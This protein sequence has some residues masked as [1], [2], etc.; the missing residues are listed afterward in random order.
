MRQTFAIDGCVVPFADGQSILE[1]AQAAG[2]YIPRLCFDS[3]VSA[4]GNCRLCMV[5]VGGR[6]LPSCIT[7]AADGQEVV[8]QS[9]ELID[10]RRALTRM[11]F[12][13][14]NHFCP[15]CE[16]S[17][18]CK[19]QAVAYELEMLDFHY[20]Q[21]WPTRDVDASH[22]DVWLDRDR[23]IMCGLCV[24]ASRELD[25]KNVFELGG[26]G[27]TTRLMVNSPSGLLADS[28]VQSTDQAVDVCPVGALLP[29]RGAFAV[30]IGWRRYDRG[31][32][33]ARAIQKGG[34]WHA[35]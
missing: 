25:R 8:S 1:A 5:T 7:P 35:D 31:T 20:S 34:Q 27:A 2:I 24:R 11:L 32:I 15:S 4:S 23:C 10:L 33:S 3:R 17:G 22:P 19:L 30:P 28:D 29:K 26:R 13:E 14:G 18:N 12:V 21:L 16:K 6:T 9:P